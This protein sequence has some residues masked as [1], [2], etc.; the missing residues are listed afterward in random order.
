MNQSPKEKFHSNSNDDHDDTNN[1]DDVQYYEIS[2][3]VLPTTQP[4]QPQPQRN[5]QADDDDTNAAA[6]IGDCDV[7]DPEV[8]LHFLRGDLFD[9]KKYNILL[10]FT[11]TRIYRRASRFVSFLECS[12]ALFGNAIAD[13][14]STYI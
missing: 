4:Q 9:S 10:S 6:S 14:T 8:R 2:C 5:Y 13:R 7:N 3:K 12:K 11:M 1:N